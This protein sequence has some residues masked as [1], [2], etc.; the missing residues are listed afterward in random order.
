MQV[1]FLDAVAPV[2]DLAV[3]LR[4]RSSLGDMVLLL[5]GLDTLLTPIGNPQSARRW[6]RP[7]ELVETRVGGG[8]GSPP[9][10]ARERFVTAP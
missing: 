4:S 6:D 7:R 8:G 3:N 9:R 2:V 10:P 5:T 1:A